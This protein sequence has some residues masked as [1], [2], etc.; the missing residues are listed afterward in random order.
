M[1]KL[2]P[3]AANVAICEALGLDATRVAKGGVTIRLESDGPFVDVT[4]HLYHDD[5]K[6]LLKGVHRYR[7]Q[8]TED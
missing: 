3:T 8:L 2:D 1:N 7:L 5:V 4:Y 6:T